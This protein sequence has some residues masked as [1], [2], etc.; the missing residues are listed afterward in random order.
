VPCRKF[1]YHEGDFPQAEKA[2]QETL[3]LPMYPEMTE[4]QQDQ[5]ITAISMFME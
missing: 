1:G 2:S 3:A 5:V 4:A